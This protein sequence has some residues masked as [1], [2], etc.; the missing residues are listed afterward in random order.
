MNEGVID[1][2]IS[3]NAI[4]NKGAIAV[5]ASLAVSNLGDVFFFSAFL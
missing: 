4:R 5:I 2:D 1:L 3:W